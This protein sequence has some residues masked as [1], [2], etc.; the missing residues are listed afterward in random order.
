MEQL[1]KII[2]YLDGEVISEEKQLFEKELDADNSLRQMLCLVQ[3]V[4]LTIG[5]GRLLSYID[6][7]KE[8]QA[9]VNDEIAHNPKKRIMQ[10]WKMLAAACLT[11]VVVASVIFYS[12]YS[13]PSSDKVFANFYH[14]YEADLLTRSA[15][16]SEVNDLIKAIQLYDLGNYKEAIT[17]FEAIIKT[18]ETNTTAHFF[19]GVSFIET[20]NYAKAIDNLTYV[21]TQNDT[22]FV[23]HA[24]WYL[25]LCYL[26]TNQINQATLLLH[27]I[28]N[29]TTFYKIMAADILKKLK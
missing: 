4:E 2:R 1:E 8:A 24:E 3:E 19:I 15:E 23:E 17:K 13:K 12:N 20:K 18:D 28:A 5:D 29:S 25:S 26:K 21:V 6:C 11:I 9:K 27:K 10:S 22:A 7:L 16:P 14:K